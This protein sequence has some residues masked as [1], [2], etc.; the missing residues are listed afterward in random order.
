MMNTVHLTGFGG[1][2]RPNV[3]AYEVLHS[4]I[5]AFCRVLI[6][7]SLLQSTTKAIAGEGVRF[8][9]IAAREGNQSTMDD[10]VYRALARHAVAGEPML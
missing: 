9:V 7:K 1:H 10:P 8:E 2:N 5:V 6:H 4:L 3:V